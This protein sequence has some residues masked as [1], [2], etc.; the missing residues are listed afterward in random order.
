MRVCIGSSLYSPFR[1]FSQIL[2]Y[3]ISEL[4]A[5]A[6]LVHK[7][8]RIMTHELFEIEMVAVV[9]VH[10]MLKEILSLILI[11]CSDEE[12]RVIP[13]GAGKADDNS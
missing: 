7:E 2:D 6:G 10:H 13:P 5:T 8:T 3:Q 11:S 12:D 1:S 4:Y 9:L